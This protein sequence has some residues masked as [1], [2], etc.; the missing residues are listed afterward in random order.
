MKTKWIKTLIESDD[1]WTTIPMKIG[2][3]NI[4]KFW[5]EYPNL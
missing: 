3:E 5:D 1:V 2:I 4:Y